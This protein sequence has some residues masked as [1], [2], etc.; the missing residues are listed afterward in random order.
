M[1]EINDARKALAKAADKTAHKIRLRLRGLRVTLP[2]GVAADAYKL[3]C[4]YSE[5]LRNL[6]QK[7]TEG[8]EG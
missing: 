4:G 8:G 7:E 3:L 2:A 1:S 5:L 6:M